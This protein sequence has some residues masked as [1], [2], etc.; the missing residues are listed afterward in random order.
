MG[1]GSGILSI[2]AKKLGFSPV[3]GFDVDKEAVDAS[4][5]NAAANGVDVDFMHYGLGSRTKPAFEPADMVVA[6][7]LGPLLIRFADE[8]APFAKKNLVISGILTELYPEVLSA[9]ESRG[10]KEVSRKTIGEWT[11]GLLSACR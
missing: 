3:C 1:C 7:I 6:N 2:A 4:C 10:F 9:Y 11:T 5:E 8:I